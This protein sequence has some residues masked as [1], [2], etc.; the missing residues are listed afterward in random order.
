MARRGV[1][2]HGSARQGKAGMDGR[3]RHG[4]KPFRRY[5]MVYQWKD[6][7]RLKA[8]AEKVGNEIEQIKG[9]KTPEA[10]VKKARSER[11]E[12]HKCFEWDDSA[13]AIQYRLE[14]ARYVLRTIS[15]V[16]E[17]EI[18]G[19]D[20]PRKV[21]VRAY[22]NVNTA[23]G[24]DEQERAYVATEAALAQPEL[25]AQ[26]FNRLSRMIAEATEIADAYRYLSPEISALGDRLHAIKS[27]M[28][29][30]AKSA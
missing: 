17:V 20:T 25:R 28:K 24:D 3:G 23:K 9:P 2:W 30:G 12:L 6:G 26:I 19:S 13:A 16:R 5:F 27:E 4:K 21:V 22:E 1:A 11:T 8:D 14:Q 10:V 7:T 18:P 15:I 29:T